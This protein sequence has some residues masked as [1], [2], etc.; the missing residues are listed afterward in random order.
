VNGNYVLIASAAY[1]VLSSDGGKTYQLLT[2]MSNGLNNNLS[3]PNLIAGPSGTLAALGGP[4]ASYAFSTNNG[5]AWSRATA[6]TNFTGYNLLTYSSSLGMYLA[7]QGSGNGFMTSVNLSSWTPGTLPTS[8]T[9]TWCN[10]SWTGTEFVLLPGDT[11]GL[12]LRSADGSHWTAWSLPTLGDP[13]GCSAL[14]AA[15]RVFLFGSTSPS[16]SLVTSDDNVTMKLRTLPI[17]SNWID[18]D[19]NDNVL[20]AITNSSSNYVALSSDNG[21]TWVFQPMASPTS[22]QLAVQPWK[23][24]A[25]HSGVE[26][27]VV[28]SGATTT[29]YA[30]SKDGVTWSSQTLPAAANAW[31]D[32]LANGTAVA[33]VGNNWGLISYDGV[34]WT[35]FSAPPV[36]TSLARATAPNR[37]VIAGPPAGV[38]LLS[39]AYDATQSFQIP[40]VPA[41]PTWY[42]KAKQGTTSSS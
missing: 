2:P 22:G 24:I 40:S 12:I 9:A 11:S 7:I 10:V 6:N 26:L 27:F 23:A 3:W 8:A 1:T 19:C 25:W 16:Q 36:V 18:V 31:V 34:N 32:C 20:V 35:P 29:A 14:S 13:V 37:F 38:S 39:D 41:A 5:Q 17:N 15:R 33:I 21:N 4:T 42:V 30:V 28:V